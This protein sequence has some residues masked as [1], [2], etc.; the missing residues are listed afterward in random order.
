M[1]NTKLKQWCE[2]SRE[3]VEERPKELGIV[4][5]TAIILPDE[6]AAKAMTKLVAAEADRSGSKLMYLHF[7]NQFEVMTK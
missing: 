1:D 6:D 7:P 3:I 5:V 2:L 4:L